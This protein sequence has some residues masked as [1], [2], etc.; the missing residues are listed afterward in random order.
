MAIVIKAVV[1]QLGQLAILVGMGAVI[2]IHANQK[3][4]EVSFVNGTH[5]GN[6]LLG[7]NAFFICLKHDGSSMGIVGGNI[8]TFVPAHS[9]EAH[10]DIGLGVFQN[11]PKM[12]CSI[13]IGQGV[14]DQY[15][16]L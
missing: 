9:L 1:D 16:A 8:V 14:G 13:G 10:P 2:V 4:P 11:M 15:L 3:V 6:M 5:I 7:T 12:Q